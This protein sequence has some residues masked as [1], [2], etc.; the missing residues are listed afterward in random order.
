MTSKTKEFKLNERIVFSNEIVYF[1]NINP[2]NSSIFISLD[3]GGKKIKSNMPKKI[4]LKDIIINNE[5]EE[6]NYKLLDDIEIKMKFKIINKF[7]KKELFESFQ[8]TMRESR[9]RW[10]QVKKKEGVKF[11]PGLSI[12]DRVRMFTCVDN[13]KQNLTCRNKKPGK[14]KMPIMFQA[15]NQ[16]SIKSLSSNKSNI[17]GKKNTKI[18]NENNAENKEEIKNIKVIKLDNN[19]EKNIINNEKIDNNNEKNIIKNEILKQNNI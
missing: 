12:Q 5:S 1:C 18:K 11:I 14:L 4:N 2:Y 17:K 19:N 7:D 6:I 16:N 3:V 13:K 10:N 15:S 8:N 9:Q